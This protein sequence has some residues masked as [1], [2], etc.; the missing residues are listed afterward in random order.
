MKIA[1]CSA[2]NVLKKSSVLIWVQH[3]PA[4]QPAAAMSWGGAI[5]RAVGDGSVADLAD[6]QPEARRGFDTGRGDLAHVR[7]GPGEALQGYADARP[8]ITGKRR[9]L[10]ACHHAS[11]AAIA[12]LDEERSPGGR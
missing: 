12:A 10:C 3:S 1:C 6:R 11:A 2:E 4:S 5:K 7:A 8:L 9:D